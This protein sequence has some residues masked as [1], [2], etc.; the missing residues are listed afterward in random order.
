MKNFLGRFNKRGFLSMLA[1]MLCLGIAATW[2]N[3]LALASSG[4]IYLVFG[5]C[6]GVPLII[7]LIGCFRQDK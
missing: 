1:F 6:V 7:S 3:F 2:D 4:R 5:L